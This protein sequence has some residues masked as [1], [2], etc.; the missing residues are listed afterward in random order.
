VV[1][2]NVINSGRGERR[3]PAEQDHVVAAAD[4]VR[5]RP[6][7]RL[8]QHEGDQ[9]RGHDRRDDLGIHLHAVDQELLHVGREGIEI[10]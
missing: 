4:P 8:Q 3:A 9:H 6:E 1:L 10:E 2:D 5:K 7:N